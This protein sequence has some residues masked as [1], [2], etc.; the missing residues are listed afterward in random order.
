[1]AKIKLTKGELKRQRDSLKQFQRYL[2]TLQ[3]KKQQLQLE[4]LQQNL[5][6]E[7][8][9]QLLFKKREL[10]EQWLGLF[11]D[12]PVDFKSFLIPTKIITHFKNI[13]G[14]DIPVFDQ[15]EFSAADYDLFIMPLWVDAA[16]DALRALIALNKEISTVI[17]G[18]VLLR[19][20]LRVTTQRV[21][22]FEKVKIPE[23]EENI[24][25]IKIYIGDQMANAVGR[26]KIAKRKIEE[27][28]LAGEAA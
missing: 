11:A 13:A 5:I 26:C 7:E 12:K 21:N 1:M 2:P 17:Q 15:V 28:V 24:R 22:L 10:I 25:L 16:I 27:L 6:L 3:L 8:K 20:E 14:I 4:I 18:V 9:N 19:Q 23:A